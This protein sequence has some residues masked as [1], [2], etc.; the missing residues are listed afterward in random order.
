MTY[1]NSKKVRVAFFRGLF[2]GVLVTWPVLSGLMAV[3]LCLGAAVGVL[4][5]W[6]VAQGIYFASITAL[7]IGY[8]DLVPTQGMTR[9]LS[10]AIGVGGVVFVALIAA[11]AVQ[12]LQQ[13]LSE[14]RPASKQVTTP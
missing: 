8:G 3:N 12:A 11:L 6:G 2:H 7:T 1:A 9:A 4:E 13:A 14:L 5:G 10:I